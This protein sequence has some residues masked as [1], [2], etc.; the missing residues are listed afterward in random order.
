MYFP[1]QT[2]L[3]PG[4]G[5]VFQALSPHDM[6][7]WE[8]PITKIILK[9][10]IKKIIVKREFF[11][12]RSHL[13]M[14]VLNMTPDSFSDGGK[15]IKFKS[16]D[17]QINNLI[18]SGANIIDIGGESTR[19]GAKEITVSDEWKRISKKLRLIRKKKAIFSLDT[20]KSQVMEKSLNYG[21]KIIPD[22]LA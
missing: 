2:L 5:T 22:L 19:P 7:E 9:A 16:A 17:R 13:I 21:I 20:R 1:S 11:G 8:I 15:F 4:L 12:K 18:N 14:G 3:R 10:F 6:L